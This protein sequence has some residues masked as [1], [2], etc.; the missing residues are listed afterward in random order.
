MALRA[1]GIEQIVL[2]V[3]HLEDQIREKIGDGGRFGLLIHYVSDGP[4]LLGTGGALKRAEGLLERSVL[5]AVWRLLPASGLRRGGQ[6][7]RRGRDTRA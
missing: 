1:Q 7:V 2:S 3:G 5:R 4:R 6:A